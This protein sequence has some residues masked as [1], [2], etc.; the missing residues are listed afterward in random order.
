MVDDKDDS[1]EDIKDRNRRLRAEAAARRAERRDK[2]HEAQ[3]L[4]LD[5]GEQAQDVLAR[6]TDSAWR[7]I[8]K[9]FKVLQWVWVVI[10]VGLVAWWIVATTDTIAA[11]ETSDTFAEGL[12]AQAGIIGDP[13]DPKEPIAGIPDVRTIYP[14]VAERLSV[15][16][17][18]YQETRDLEPGSG[19]AQVS[20]LGTAVVTYEQGKYTDAKTQFEAVAEGNLAL[21]DED[22]R[23]RALEGAGLSAEAAGELDAA[24]NYF[25]KMEK[26][27]APRFQLQS[28]LHQVRLLNALAKTEAAQV[29]NK[30]LQV[31]AMKN[32][33]MGMGYLASATQLQSALVN[34]LL[35]QGELL[36]LLLAGEKSPAEGKKAATANEGGDMVDDAATAEDAAS[37]SPDDAAP[38]AGDAAPGAAEGSGGGATPAP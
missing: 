2:L 15:A 23:G 38:P 3:N 35:D 25:R 7:W 11:R 30:R 21:K 13:T 8:K 14:T 18:A 31:E 32:G 4:G 10:I 19:L 9:N 34:P 37:G 28:L 5:A 12:T 26:L 6:S 36:N 27:T 17:K 16:A 22:V 1:T 24:L 29:A 20:E 33:K